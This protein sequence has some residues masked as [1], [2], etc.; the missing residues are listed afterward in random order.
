M[1]TIT[2]QTVLT[3]TPEEMFSSFEKMYG[4]V[5]IPEEALTVEDLGRI[6]GILGWATN[7]K[8]Y[9][10]SLFVYLDIA[11]RRAKQ[12]G[13][14]ETYSEMVCRKNVVK[15]YYDRVDDIYKVC[16]RQATIW[17]EARKENDEI[18]RQEKVLEDL[19]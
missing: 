16:S 13:D 6:S 14:K 9:L 11:T 7:N 4:D 15:A 10:N 5:Y 17:I 2:I 18:K 8:A 12:S 19:K 3:A 1:R